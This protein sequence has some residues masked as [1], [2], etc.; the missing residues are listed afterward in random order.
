V[1]RAAA[2]AAGNGPKCEKTES[3]SGAH[4]IVLTNSYG[5]PWT[6]DGFRIVVNEAAVLK[7]EKR[8]KL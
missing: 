1:W 7:L 3:S 6:S 2:N 5:R 4:H 8:T